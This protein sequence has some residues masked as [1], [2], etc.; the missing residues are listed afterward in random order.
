M[1]KDKIKNL[2]QIEI[3]VLLLKKR[4]NMRKLWNDLDE[5]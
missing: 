1:K 2:K 4:I 3:E 5:F